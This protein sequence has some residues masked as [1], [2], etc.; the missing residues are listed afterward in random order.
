MDN[1]SEIRDFMM[2]RRA[3]V[4]PQQVDLPVHGPRRVPGLRRSEV[5]RL[6]G[7]SIEY[8]TRLE[9]GNLAGVSDSVL[10]AVARALRLDDAERTHLADLARNCGPAARRRRPD[11]SRKVRPNL[12]RLLDALTGAPGFV[13]DRRADLVA[14]NPL[15]RALLA[16]LYERAGA[17]N[18]ARFVFLDARAAQFWTDWAKVADD[19][20]ALLH[21]QA[22]R[23][24]YDK[25]LTELI[26][27]L[28]TRSDQFRTRWARHDVRAHTTGVKRLQHPVV[29]PLELTFEVLMPAADDDQA[30]VVYCAEP[31]SASAD[32]LRLLAGWA[33]TGGGQLARP[34]DAPLPNG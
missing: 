1:R 31:G 20:V 16:P 26:G 7:V 27:E 29:G 17:P 3:K 10:D 21:V 22:A 9:R 5:A 28:S 23:Y 14:A 4:S 12:Q 24:P 32:G 34:D 15:G 13:L 30:L 2:S 33:A 18:H 11:P 8:Y 19:V 6:A 25:G